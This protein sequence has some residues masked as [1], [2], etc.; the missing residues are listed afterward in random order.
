MSTFGHGEALNE[1]SDLL[2]VTEELATNIEVM[3]PILPSDPISDNLMF[4]QV[5]SQYDEKDNLVS[6]LEKKLLE[7]SNFERVLES[8]VQRCQSNLGSLQSSSM[9]LEAKE[10]QRNMHRAKNIQLDQLTH[11]EN[12]SQKMHT[13]LDKADNIVK[14][15]HEKR[16]PPYLPPIESQ[17]GLFSEPVFSPKYTDKPNT[18]LPYSANSL[19]EGLVELGPVQGGSFDYQF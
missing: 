8:E 7:L 4:Q 17:S 11:V 12:L 3:L 16:C 2:P 14:A 6:Q 15:A 5:K 1:L 13:I 18:L 10:A 19:L 9:R